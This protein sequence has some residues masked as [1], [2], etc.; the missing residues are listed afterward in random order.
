MKRLLGIA[1]AAACAFTASPANALP[2]YAILIAQDHCEYLRNGWTW[3]D[4][5]TQSLR[6]NVLWL[7]EMNADGDR[8]T[9]TIMIAIRNECESL[10]R[11]AWNAR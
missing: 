10:N 4:A 7:D 6:D 5:T 11:A 3:D 8:A 9:G 1:A 2:T